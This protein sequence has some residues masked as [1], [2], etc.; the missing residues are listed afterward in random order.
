MM[1]FVYAYA[2]FI[3]YAFLGWVCEDLYCGIPAKKF[4]NR[5]FLY[6][7]YCPI[8]G[9]G[10]LLILY[11][12][13]FV[14]DYPILVFILGVIITSTLEYITSWVMEILF[15]TRWW[16]YSERFMNI[17]GRVC[18]LNST[19]FGI[20]SIVVVYI[21]HPI[22]QDIVLDI[23]FTALM[24]FLS[25]FTIGFGIDCVFTV[26]ALLRRKK[27]FQK[28]QTQMEAFKKDFEAESQLR[29]Q[30]AQE[31]FQEWMLSRPDLSERIEELQNSLD[32]FSLE[33]KKHISRAFPERRIS[34]EIRNIVADGR[35]A[36]EKRRLSANKNAEFCEL[37]SMVMI[38]DDKGNVLVQE[39]Q[40]PNG[41]TLPTGHI[42][43]GESFVQS[44]IHGV[45]EKTGLDV[46]QLKL[47]GT[48]QFTSSDGCRHIVFLYK[49]NVFNGNK[50]E[51][52]NWIP[53]SKIHDY[54]LISGLDDVLDVF[55]ELDCN[56]RYYNAQYQLKKY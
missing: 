37:T 25:A 7:P 24:S 11:P 17:N 30:E 41:Y 33:A 3:L 35:L 8:Y 47:C 48:K 52:S 16:D 9:F 13:L 21:I 50:N 6:G 18:L 43:L 54:K 46:D 34:T 40:N 27:V 49:T 32:N 26:L 36:I 23:P 39:Q 14:K 31:A 42:E 28:V 15:K 38:Q 12:L 2:Y 5:G 4:I 10:A 19:L 53:L 1:G 55:K 20:M 45:K 29:V 22:I 56:E 51:E 44:A